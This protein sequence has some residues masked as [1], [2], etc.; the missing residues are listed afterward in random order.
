M[1]SCYPELFST[2]YTIFIST[3][4]LHFI[5]SIVALIFRQQPSLEQLQNGS[6]IHLIHQASGSFYLGPSVCEADV[7]TRSYSG[8]SWF[9]YLPGEFFKARTDCY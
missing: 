7:C 1:V 8:C 5:F 4:L 6:F 2:S 3:R 9:E